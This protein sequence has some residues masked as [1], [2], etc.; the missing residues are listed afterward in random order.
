MSTLS[1]QQ[2]KAERF[3]ELHTGPGILVLPNAWD[4]V[5]ARILEDLGYPAI[6]T[7]SAGVA[8]VLGF[9]DGQYVPRERMLE[10]VRRIVDAVQVPVTADMESGYGLPNK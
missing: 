7:T 4:V 5:S 6:A 9:P 8:A 3:R 2:Q 10:S 1:E